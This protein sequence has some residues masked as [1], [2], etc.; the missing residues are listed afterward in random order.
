MSLMCRSE[1]L[2]QKGS[3]FVV[4]WN[5]EGNPQSV[6]PRNN[7][8]NKSREAREYQ[9]GDEVQVKVKEGSQKHEGGWHW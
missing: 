9:A 7:I 5:E 1:K 8:I 2:F 3:L 6:A 4:A